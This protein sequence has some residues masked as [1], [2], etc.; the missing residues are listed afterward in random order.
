MP[1]IDEFPSEE[2][3]RN[4]I[5]IEETK[6]YGD[7]LENLLSTIRNKKKPI[8][9]IREIDY[10]NDPKIELENGFPVSIMTFDYSR[11]SLYKNEI[12]CPIYRN[13]FIFALGIGGKFIEPIRIIHGLGVYTFKLEY[14]TNSLGVDHRSNS[15]DRVPKDEFPPE[16]ILNIYFNPNGKGEG[17]GKYEVVTDEAQ[18]KTIVEEAVKTKNEEWVKKLLVTFKNFYFQQI[19][20]PRILNK[21]SNITSTYGELLF[22]MKTLKKELSMLVKYHELLNI[23]GEIN[24]THY[25]I[26]K[27]DL[28]QLDST[29]MAAVDFFESRD[30]YENYNSLTEHAHFKKQDGVVGIGSGVKTITDVLKNAVKRILGT[31]FYVSFQD[32][33][34]YPT[35]VNTFLFSQSTQYVGNGEFRNNESIRQMK[36]QAL[37][38][39]ETSANQLGIETLKKRYVYQNFIPV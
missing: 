6:L 37:R 17:K 39:A 18:W 26:I 20:T 32:K 12:A 4:E 14:G 2:E 38:N 1:F 19:H 10:T 33:K 30:P 31:G 27:A 23:F 25:K 15:R 11:E 8:L 36:E 22:D 16:Y 3:I 9:E 28:K 5:E 34:V 24:D 29:I 35:I 13:L 7:T 21:L